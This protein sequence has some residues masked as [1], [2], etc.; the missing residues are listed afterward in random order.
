MSSEPME[1]VKDGRGFQKTENFQVMNP[2]EVNF[3]TEV[4]LVERNPCPNGVALVDADKSGKA[5]QYD[6]VKLATQ[7][8]T[9]DKFTRSTAGSKL[10]VIAEQV[11]F[12]QQQAQ[13]ILEEAALNNQLHHIACNFKKVPGKIYYV[14]KRDSGKHYMSMISP[15]EWGKSCPPFVAAY[16]LEHDM[17][18]TPFD[19][20]AKRED[21]EKIIDKIL[22]TNSNQLSLTFN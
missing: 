11:R 3:Q 20:I 10:Q 15:K 6:L 17:T 16:K 14:Y 5:N 22:K 7:I 18:F 13:S 2:N 21:D 4:N 1:S 8:Q 9:A 19:K 12:L